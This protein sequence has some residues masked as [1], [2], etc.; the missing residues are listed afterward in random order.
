M[1]GI[2]MNAALQREYNIKMQ[3]L[4]NNI[5]WRR[6]NVFITYFEKIHYNIHQINNFLQNFENQTAHWHKLCEGAIM[7]T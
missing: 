6:S 1:Y 2:L 5:N 3:R 4:W 7:M